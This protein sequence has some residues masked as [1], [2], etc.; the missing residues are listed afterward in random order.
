[1]AAGLETTSSGVQR[2]ANLLVTLLDLS[3]AFSRSL[4]LEDPAQQV[5]EE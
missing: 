2:E 4:L 5:G 3:D 1:M